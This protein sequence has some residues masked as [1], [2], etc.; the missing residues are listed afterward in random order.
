M[1]TTEYETWQVFDRGQFVFWKK[2]KENFEEKKFEKIIFWKK[3]YFEKNYILKKNWYQW[4]A[5]TEYETWQV[6]DR[7]QF[8]F[9]KKKFGKNWKKILDLDNNYLIKKSKENDLKNIYA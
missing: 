3:L 2:K 1:A 4:V 8:V 9:W 5:T 6:S 7:G